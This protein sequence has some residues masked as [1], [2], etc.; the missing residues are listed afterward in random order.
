MKSAKEIVGLAEQYIA[1]R[2]TW[3]NTWQE[4][5]D[6]LV[7]RRDFVTKGE[8]GGRQRLGKIYD[9][10]GMRSAQLFASAIS[11][12]LTNPS[13]KWFN[14]AFADKG[15]RQNYDFQLWLQEVEEV[16]RFAFNRPEARQL[17]PG[18][19][20]KTC[21]PA[22]WKAP[23]ILSGMLYTRAFSQTTFLNAEIAKF[24]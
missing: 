15:M 18:T 5:S 23:L 12:L 10:T 22:A 6:N 2:G 8:Q 24:P 3:E 1:A 7:G 11:S 4:V 14:L 21:L 19:R 20:M 16:V 9:G 13:T 17:P